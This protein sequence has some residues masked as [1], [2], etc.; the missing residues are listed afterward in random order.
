MSALFSP[1]IFTGWDSE[2]VTLTVVYPVRE[3]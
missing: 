3:F 2:G 1:E